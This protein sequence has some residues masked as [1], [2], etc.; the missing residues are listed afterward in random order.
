[1]N[2]ER[3]ASGADGEVEGRPPQIDTLHHRLTADG[4]MWR[5]QWPPN[6][7]ITEETV[8]LALKAADSSS[9]VMSEAPGQQRQP[10]ASGIHAP[11]FGEVTPAS[12]STRSDA[13]SDAD[14]SRTPASIVTVGRRSAW[15]PRHHFYSLF[16]AVLVVIIGFAAV[17]GQIYEAHQSEYRTAPAPPLYQWSP[18]HT[19]NSTSPEDAF[20]KGMVLTPCGG[21]PTHATSVTWFAQSPN[22]GIAL[23]RADC[24]MLGGQQLIWLFTLG[25]TKDNRW[26]PQAGYT[27]P[28]GPS[29]AVQGSTAFVPAWLSLPYDQYVKFTM[30]PGGLNPEASVVAWYSNTRT[31]AAGHFADQ[32]IRPAQ[33]VT[34]ALGQRSAWMTQTGSLVSIVVPL[35]DGTTFFF[36]GT[37][38]TS[39]T[40]NYA[41]HAL[42]HLD[43]LLPPL[44]R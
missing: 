36:A 37:A 16:A 13:A 10:D 24:R 21:K 39:E 38:S 23:I 3:H 31:F 35:A 29:V 12:N 32:A 30:P 28:L 8:L 5:R 14:A 4:A 22:Y 7:H 41:R 9:V 40:E 11:Q 26:I 27:A 43:E 33:A 42:A 44:P 1:M 20:D 34:L 6:A 17:V 2:N 19:L 15:P 18:Q 25:K